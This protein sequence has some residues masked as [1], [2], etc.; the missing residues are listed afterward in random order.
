MKNL[1]LFLNQLQKLRLDFEKKKKLISFIGK[2]NI[3]KGYDVFGKSILKILDKYPDW[4]S[5]VIGDEP[6]QKL[7][8][9]HKNLIH[10]GFKS[11]SYV[12]NTA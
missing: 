2:L 9:N 1:S 8:F 4:K 3:S 6:R 10:L 12:L 7:F 5:I 11:N